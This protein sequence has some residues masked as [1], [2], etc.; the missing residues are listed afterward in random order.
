MVAANRLRE[1]FLVQLWRRL[2][3]SRRARR[4]RL[5]P[6]PRHLVRATIAQYYPG[7]S[8]VHRLDPRSKAL[9][10]SALAVAP[11]APTLLRP[12]RL[13][14]RRGVVYALQPRN[15]AGFGAPSGRCCGRW[16]SPSWR[17]Y[18]SLVVDRSS[19]WGS[20]I[21]RHTALLGGRT[22]SLRRVLVLAGSAL[23]LTTPPMALTDGLR[24]VGVAPRRCGRPPTSWRSW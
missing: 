16:V 9:A 15:R 12:R 8:A 4:A 22:C 2:G 13:R 18:S 1:P 23:T 14:G 7:V 5:P 6:P 11:S 20:S 3:A 19:A 10:V 21:C 24:L 17:R